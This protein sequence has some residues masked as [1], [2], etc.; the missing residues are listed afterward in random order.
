MVLS[1]RVP[2]HHCLSIIGP[3]LAA[4]C[5]HAVIVAMVVQ[6]THPKNVCLNLEKNS[7]PRQVLLC[8]S[9]MQLE[10][11]FT[12]HKRHLAH[13]AQKMRLLHDI[14]VLSAN[15]DWIGARTTAANAGY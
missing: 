6:K 5:T 2:I 4:D 1:I 9:Y 11:G 8:V 7:V 14:S 15:L 13:N 3:R 10:S 12:A